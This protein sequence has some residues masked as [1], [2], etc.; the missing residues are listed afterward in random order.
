MKLLDAKIV[1]LG[2]ALAA[3]LT[4]G[5][6][7]FAQSQTPPAAPAATP[8]PGMPCADGQPCGP[9]QGRGPGHRHGP[10]HGGHGAM[11]MDTDGDGQLSKAELQAAQQRQLQA[12]DKADANADG[13]LTRD[14][15]RAY[16]QSLHA[17]AGGPGGMRHGMGPGG[18]G[19][20]GMG[21]GGMGPGGAAPAPQKN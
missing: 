4:A 6:L 17:A 16:R 5:T 15:M 3:T 1:T 14:E 20:G 11:A 9:G 7:A 2:A 10:R 19:P 12:F 13:K 8:A 21:P 18:M